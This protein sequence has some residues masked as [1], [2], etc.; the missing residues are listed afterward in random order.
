MRPVTGGVAVVTGGAS[1]IG[2]ALARALTAEGMRALLLDLNEQRLSEA[3]AELPGSVAMVVDIG[4]EQAV[5]AA[6]K[7]CL[8]EMG[9]ALVIC[10]NAGIGGPTANVAWET[11]AADWDRVMRVNFLGAVR[12]VEAFVPQVL[13]AGGGHVIITASM[14][15]VTSAV[16]MGP[17]FAA[18]HAL[19]SFA[20]TLRLQVLRDALPLGVSVLLPS[21]VAT[22][23]HESHEEGF[24]SAAV[25]PNLPDALDPAVV[26]ALA[27][28]SMADDRFYVFT[29]PSSRTRVADWY[30]GIEAAYDVLEHGSR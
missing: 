15:G 22:N 17:Y 28:E 24:D 19:V 8:D 4:D 7:R 30:A 23:L 20:E 16:A 10:A 13:D 14:A 5:A 11:P 6:A 9:P 27:I 25:V 1:G 18:K 2:L 12:T 3:V 21:R 26:A 29:H